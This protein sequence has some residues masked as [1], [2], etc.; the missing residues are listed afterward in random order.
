MYKQCLL[1]FFFFLIEN[2]LI[3]NI[4]LKKGFRLNHKETIEDS[5]K[6]L[7]FHSNML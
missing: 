4:Y 1:H 6:S 5:R 3:L 7:R 2:I